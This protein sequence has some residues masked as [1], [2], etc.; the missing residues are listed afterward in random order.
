MLVL[1]VDDVPD[2]RDVYE[3]FLTYKGI[4]VVTANDGIE[5]L[6]MAR[7]LKPDAI[8][9]DLGLPRMHGWDVAR[10]LKA[11]PLTQKICIVAVTGHGTRESRDL[12]IAAGVNGFLVKPVKPPDLYDELQRLLIRAA[13]DDS[14]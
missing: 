3:Q 6:E 1:I 13:R 9:L 10:R 4:G 14:F 11:D 8:I 7:R 2:N 5:G 12:A